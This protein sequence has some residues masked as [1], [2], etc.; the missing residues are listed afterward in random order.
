[1]TTNI[2][3]KEI[4]LDHVNSSFFFASRRRH[5]MSKRDW[6]SD[7][8]SSDLIE[9]RIPYSSKRV[10]FLITGKSKESNESVVIVEL[11][12]WE[13]VEKIEGKEAIVKTPMRYG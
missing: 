10:D 8:C 12:Q 11:K 2:R 3:E 9:F 4:A 6:S 1:M 5:T 7:V 13:K